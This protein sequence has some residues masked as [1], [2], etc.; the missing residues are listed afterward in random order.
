MVSFP[1][2]PIRVGSMANQCPTCGQLF[3]SVTAFDEHREGPYSSRRCLTT[4]EMHQKGMRQA[5]GGEWTT[6]W[7]KDRPKNTP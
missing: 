6:K 5:P 1:K 2:K 7:S 3:H 4:E